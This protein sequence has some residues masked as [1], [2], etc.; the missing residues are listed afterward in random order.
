MQHAA[1]M[2]IGVAGGGSSGATYSSGYACCG[3]AQENTIHPRSSLVQN[4]VNH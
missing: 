3:T 2:E 1:T 4:L